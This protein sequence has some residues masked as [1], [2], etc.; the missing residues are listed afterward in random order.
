MEPLQSTTKI[1]NWNLVY[2][3]WFKNRAKLAATQIQTYS[4]TKIESAPHTN[5]F[6]TFI[7]RSKVICHHGIWIMSSSNSVLHAI[8][9]RSIRQDSFVVVSLT[10]STIRRS[11][12]RITQQILNQLKFYLQHRIQ[13]NLNKLFRFIRLINIYF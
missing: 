11:S 2:G 6:V 13:M 1:H 12:D 3:W 7:Q 5:R 4:N 10:F 9:V 8:S